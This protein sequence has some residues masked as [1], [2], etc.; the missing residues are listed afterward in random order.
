MSAE[1]LFAIQL[2]GL[3]AI[4]GALIFFSFT[5]LTLMNAA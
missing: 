4:A 5:T 2:S 3:L 1:T